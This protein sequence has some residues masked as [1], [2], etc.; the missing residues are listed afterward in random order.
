MPGIEGTCVHMA[1]VGSMDATLC[2]V[3][4]LPILV[5]VCMSRSGARTSCTFQGFGRCPCPAQRC[6]YTGPKAAS[7]I[8]CR[9]AE[10]RR[11]Q[12]ET[13]GLDELDNGLEATAYVS[14]REPRPIWPPLKEDGQSRASIAGLEPQRHLHWWEKMTRCMHHCKQRRGSTLLLYTFLVADSAS[15]LDDFPQTRP[16]RPFSRMPDSTLWH[17]IQILAVSHSPNDGNPDDGNANLA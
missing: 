12:V 17:L 3:V 8:S 1:G 6:P 4:V 13:H 14:V 11:A 7:G 10:L 9:D 15:K 5:N 16:H 2:A